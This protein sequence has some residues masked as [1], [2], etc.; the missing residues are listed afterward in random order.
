MQLSWGDWAPWVQVHTADRPDPADH[1]VGLA[2]EPMNCPPDAF[3]SADV[4]VL[5]AGAEHVAEWTISAL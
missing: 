1:R 5:A 2:V 4:P 3:N